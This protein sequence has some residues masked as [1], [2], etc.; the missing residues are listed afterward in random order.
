MT[1]QKKDSASAAMT[2]KID[3]S[4]VPMSHGDRSI[5]VPTFTHKVT[6]AIQMKEERSGKFGGRHE[7]YYDELHQN[8]AI[9]EIPPVEGQMDLPF[10]EESLS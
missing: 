2:I 4:L 10:F 3:I 1:M 5:T 8:F 9:R 7:I 6:S